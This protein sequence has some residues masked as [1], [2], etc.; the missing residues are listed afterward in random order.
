MLA[1]LSDDPPVTGFVFLLG[2]FFAQ[3]GL[4]SHFLGSLSLCCC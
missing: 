3:L 2:V 4:P 1:L